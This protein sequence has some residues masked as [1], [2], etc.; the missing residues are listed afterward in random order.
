VTGEPVPTCADLDGDGLASFLDLLYLLS[1][2]GPVPP[3]DLFEPADFDLDFQVGFLDL[4]I[5]L[6]QWG[7]C[8]A[9]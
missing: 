3:G 5:L 6:S 9:P 1:F 4:L 8:S 7:P 2:W